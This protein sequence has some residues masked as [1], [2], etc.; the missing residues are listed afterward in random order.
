M[1][2]GKQAS[3]A[4]LG[5]L[6]DYRKRGLP[7][8]GFALVLAVLL[9]GGFLG[10]FNA[11]RLIGN[12]R[13]VAHTDEAIVELSTL[14]ST[15]EDA[16][17]GQRGYLLTGNQAYLQP[18]Q[19][20]T[21][22]LRTELSPLRGLAAAPQQQ[23]RLAVLERTIGL[24]REEIERTV[25]LEKAGDHAG[26]VAIVRSN[27][28]EALMD[29][30]RAQVAAMQ[31]AE[32]DLLDRRAAESERSSRATIATIVVPALIGAALLCLLF[33]ISVRNARLDRRA[34][35]ALS[36]ERERLRVTLASIGDAVLTT[37]RDC[38]I[39]FANGVAESV[40]GWSSAEMLGQPL[41]AVFRIVNEQTRATV[42]S[43]TQ[44]ALRE[45]TI[46]GLANHTLLV[47][48]DGTERPID[49]SAAP[50]LDAAARVIGCVLVFRDVTERRRTEQQ[51]SQEEARVRS[52][53]DHVVDGIVTMDESGVVESVNRA[54]LTLFGYT[55]DEVVGQNV[56]LLMPEPYR[57]EHDRYLAAY[58]RTGVA[59]II[60]VGREVEGR[61]KDGSVF[62]LELAVSEFTLGPRRYFTGILRDITERKR[63]E[64]RTYDLLI[65]LKE[66]DRH[67]DEF[68][69]LLAH[70]L[71]GPLAPLRNSL[72]LLKR[73]GT[74]ESI[75]RQVRATMDRQLGQL[76]RLVNDL[77]DV[78]RIARGQIEIRSEPVDLA[79]V[80]QQ[81][82]ETCRPLV[83]FAGHTLSVSLP[84]EPV[85]VDADPA[86]LAQVLGNLLH[87]ACKYT[88]PGGRIDLAMTRESEDAVIRIKD[89]GIGIPSNKLDG[90]FDLFVQLDRTKERSQGGLGVGLALVK[91][92]VA[93]HGGS[94]EAAS[95]GPGRG[96]EF[97]VRLPIEARAR[98]SD[99]GEPHV[100]PTSPPRRVLVVDDN[101]DTATSL[102]MLLQSAGHEAYTAHEGHEA[103][104]MAEK[105]Q[106][107]VILLDI[108]LPK[109]SGH[110]VCR[111]IRERPWAKNVVVVAVTG[112]GQ[113][114]D[115][116]KS[117]EAGFD[118]HLVKPPDYAA[119]MRVLAPRE[120]VQARGEP[121]AP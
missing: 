67:K 92:L 117:A 121:G 26:A 93:M 11:Q 53:M 98:V 19:A 24:E 10:T 82:V 91:R 70:E 8:L 27:V 4:S 25:A 39:T 90:I 116:R 111:R 54:A 119:L 64:R 97:V 100:E 76:V 58:R 14:L 30:I 34:A 12:E 107:D 105:L 87:N 40:T 23:A 104:H 22:R 1:K 48:K 18:Y 29:D 41:E 35:E 61:R 6:A 32:H 101:A 16:E 9:G 74:D 2:A 106:P 78:S 84:A 72:E 112:W 33:Y 65:E 86:R 13:R 115:Q 44:R 99:S 83:T 42:E 57:G 15:L 60:G 71:R 95:E 69:A 73:A 56:K 94:V 17:T 120:T 45:G 36:A 75:R 62:P 21:E 68:L 31:A 46:V 80:V 63:I 50:I 88:E 38:R 5:T 77:L 43:P 102:S 96:S 7:I 89:T 51:R 79:A 109:L 49:D 118:A 55:A 20:A 37:D 28:G 66:A 85:H 81:A 103:L 114:E 59:K 108:G 3:P 47:R 52:I 110:E 113:E